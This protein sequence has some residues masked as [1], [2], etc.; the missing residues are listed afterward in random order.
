[1]DGFV[2]ARRLVNCCY[3]A[4]KNSNEA[5]TDLWSQ[6]GLSTKALRAVTLSGE[7]PGL[8]SS[9]RI[10]TAAQ[11]SIAAS[12]LAAA[13]LYRHRNG[14]DVCQDISVDMREASVQFR[15]ERYMRLN[16]GPAPDIT[17]I[18][19]GAFQCGDGRWIRP[20][21]VYSHHRAG[22][23]RL[24]GDVEYDRD[25]VARAMLKWNAADLEDACAEAGLVLS[26]TRSF[27]EWDMHPQGKVVAGIPPLVIEKIGD[28]PPQPLPSGASRPLEGVRVL[29][30]THVIA[31]PL[32][33]HTLA[34][35]GA[36]VMLLYAP[37]RP[38]I[39]PLVMC[40]GAGKI[41]AHLDL[42]DPAERE[43]MRGLLAR[44]DVFLQG[45]RPGAIAGHGLSPDE[46]A[47]LRPGIVCASLSAYGHEGPWRER[48]GFDSLVQNANGMN[49]AEGEAAGLD[50][51][52]ALPCQANDHV[53]G[54]LLAL[55]VM[56]ALQ[57]RAVEGGSWLVRVGLAPTAQWIRTLGRVEGGLDMPDPGQ[58]DV[59]DLL[60]DVDSGFGR[61]TIVREAAHMTETPMR[62][63]RPSV[64]LGTH[65]AEWP[66]A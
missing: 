38:S 2:L 55:G 66:E 47:A 15:C 42:R 23:L 13:E 61:L 43:K 25:A 65:P 14:A 46:V 58:D 44:S 19:F 27:E 34:G 40:S 37:H 1:M 59:A 7:E 57:R 64:P 54:Y 48:R 3:F 49:H 41:S 22:L 50:K 4:M 51:P 45:Y 30:M 16:G 21:T 28:A 60:E 20:H 29:E 6:T 24:L 8:P 5:L 56:A 26:M 9:F 39:L 33:G 31:G 53:S 10:G 36:D 18:L 12:A 17:D 11:P 63:D 35:H 52:K 62:W 32:A